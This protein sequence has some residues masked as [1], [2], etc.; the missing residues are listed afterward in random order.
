MKKTDLH[1][2]VRE[3]IQEVM[4]EETFAGIAALDDL[5]KNKKFNTLAADA[6]IAA[7]D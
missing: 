7:E 2:M 3:A 1:K 4:N 6:K 5:K